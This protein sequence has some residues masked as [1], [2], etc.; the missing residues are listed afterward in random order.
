MVPPPL[1][2]AFAVARHL[3]DR[4]PQSLL[5]VVLA[6]FMEQGHFSAHIRRMRLQYRDQR[7]ALV[8]ELV[9]RAGSHVRV[10]LPEQ[11]MRL[12]AALP[13]GSDDTRLEASALRAGVIARALSR[14]YR[15]APPQPGLLLGFTGHSR[16]AIAPAVATLARVIGEHFDAPRRRRGD[17]A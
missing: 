3:I 14:F 7:D 17:A 6:E 2:R 5:Q 1:V 13:D 16:A 8:S 10:D 15:K 9:R 4:Q 11:G 12:V